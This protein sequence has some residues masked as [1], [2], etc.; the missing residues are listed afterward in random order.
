MYDVIVVGGGPAGLSGA[1]VLGRCNRRVLMCDSKEYRNRDSR[2][3]HGF[4]SRDG[5]APDELLR[6]AREQL[7]P[8]AV[9]HITARVTG[10]RRGPRG[11]TLELADG[12]TVEGRKVLLA[13]GVVDRLPELPGLAELYGKS[14]FVCPYCDAWELRGRPLAVHGEE[15]AKLALSLRTWT[16]DVVLL[17]DGAG[18][19]TGEEAERLAAGVRVIDARVERLVGAQGQLER[20]EFRD[21]SS[22]RR[23]AMFLKLPK[24]AQRSD[25]A[26]Q[27]GAAVREECGVKSGLKAET[28]CSG[29]FV[30]GDASVDLMFAIVA[31]SEGATAAFAINCE[32]QDEEQEAMLCEQR[33]R[34]GSP[35]SAAASREAAPRA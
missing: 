24:Q 21:G 31:A 19:P 23:S 3:M 12:R 22:L 17:S 8:Y 14:V 27:L 6:L 2:A 26:Q 18:A 16:D 29:V 5:T 1:L 4:L 15:G 35:A 28:T 34:R 33:E 10:G 13:T 32:L 20:I 7:A 9:E 25:L 30:A 11:F